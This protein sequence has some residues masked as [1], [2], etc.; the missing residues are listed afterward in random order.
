MAT[1]ER[2]RAIKNGNIFTFGFFKS[3][4]GLIGMDGMKEILGFERFG[5]LP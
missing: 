5:R 4:R 2:L 3:E 1:A